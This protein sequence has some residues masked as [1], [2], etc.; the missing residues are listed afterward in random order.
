MAGALRIVSVERGHDPREFT[1]VAFG[2][3][4]PVHAARLAEELDIPR[5][6]VPPIPGGF[7][8]LGL[9]ATDVRRDYARTFYAAAERRRARRGRCRLRGHGGRGA[10]DAG[11]GRRAG[12]ALG[13]GARGRLPLPAPGLRAD[14]AAGRRAARRARRSSASPHDF[15]ER[16]RATYGHASPDEPVQLRQPARVGHRPARRRSI[17]RARQARRPARPPR[18]RGRRTSRRPASWPLP[19]IARDGLAPGAGRPGP[20]DR[21]VSRHDRGRSARLAPERRGRRADRPGETPMREIDPATFEVVKNALY[22]AAEEMKVVLA[23]TAYSP[24]LKVAGDYSCGLFDVRGEMVAQ[25]PDLPIHLGSMP[26]AV[27]AV[28]AAAER[29]SPATCSSTTIPTSAVAICPTSTSSRRPSTRARCSA[30]PAC[31]RTGR[32]S[33]APRRAPTAPPPRS[34]AR[35]C[36]CRRCAC[37]R[38]GCLNREVEAIIF[39]N[40]R[41]PDER[42]GD[43][44]AQLAANHRG[45]TRLQSWRASTGSSAA[46]RDHAGGDGLLRA[47]DAGAAGRAPRRHR[48]LRGLLRRRRH[49]RQRRQGGPAVLDPHAGATSAARR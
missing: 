2:G 1:L 30:S 27:K 24:L 23:K 19:V 40:V 22:C 41:T 11:P 37:T 48:H 46:A 32:T 26:L 5:V 38:P 49:P 36:G 33:A 44:R 47:D 6:L 42:R 43:L 28:I 39:T 34:S 20:A 17:L 25:G 45:V 7:S 35:G 10:R 31:G 8:A 3:A 21:R 16:H 12:G 14:G 13:A 18:R 29:S 9:V 15:H 4:G